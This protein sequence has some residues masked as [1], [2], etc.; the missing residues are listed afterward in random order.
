M[1]EKG[2]SDFHKLT[3]SVLKQYF[4]NP[5]P[6]IVNYRD[7]RNFRNDEFRVEFDN[8]ILKHD[9]NNI[10]SQ[11]FL[12]IFIEILH[13]HSPM[14]IKYLRANQ[15]KFVTKDL[16]KATMKRSK[17]RNKFLRDRRETSEKE[18]KK[19]IKLSG[20]LLENAKKDYFSNLNVNSVL[21]KRKFWQNVKLF[22]QTKL[23]LIQLSN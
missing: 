8:E 2:L 4:P 20:N 16:H 19:Q 18:Y 7:Y 10:E 22:S 23:N 15:G 9:I 21:D 5:K 17:L 11:H 12:N 14:K 13:K 1:F 3:N 6:K